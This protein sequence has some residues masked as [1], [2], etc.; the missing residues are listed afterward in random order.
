MPE[1]W[2]EHIKAVTPKGKVFSS[3]YGCPVGGIF[4]WEP[5]T[6]NREMPPGY[7]PFG[8]VVWSQEQA[9]AN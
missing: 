2:L 9:R 8:I 3:I 6:F 1:E 5:L 4:G 7:L